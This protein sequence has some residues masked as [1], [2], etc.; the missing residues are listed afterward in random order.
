M[1]KINK[2]EKKREVCT[3]FESSLSMQQQNEFKALNFRK[4]NCEQAEKRL[5]YIFVQQKSNEI[6]EYA[7]L[8]RSIVY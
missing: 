8:N 3:I 6:A 4:Y 5:S 2:K 7:P 1:R